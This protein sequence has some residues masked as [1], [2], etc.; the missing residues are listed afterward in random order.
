MSN[1]W[2]EVPCTEMG[3]SGKSYHF[4]LLL[5]CFILF[6]GKGDQVNFEAC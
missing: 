2:L 1:V 5:F 6:S 3:N 4:G